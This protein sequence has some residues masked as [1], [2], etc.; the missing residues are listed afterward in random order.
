[1][2][3]RSRYFW[4]LSLLLS[5]TLQ[6]CTMWLWTGKSPEEFPDLF[7]TRGSIP[8]AT[9]VLLTP[10]TVAVDSALVVAILV[11]QGCASVEQ[12]LHARR[13]CHR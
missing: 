7:P 2:H 12:E 11:A 4:I 3:R 13:S 9:K 1:M 6:G 10:V 8:T 5:A